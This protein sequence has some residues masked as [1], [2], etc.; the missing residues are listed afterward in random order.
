MS[1]K[2][3]NFST[4]PLLLAVI[5]WLYFIFAEL[6]T[7][8]AATIVV[9]L[10][11]LAYFASIVLAVMVIRR[12]GP[13]TIRCAQIALALDILFLLLVVLTMP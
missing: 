10:V 12:K 2:I 8:A 7:P 5:P 1:K 13:Q 4:Y 3:L 11:Y 9:P 6:L